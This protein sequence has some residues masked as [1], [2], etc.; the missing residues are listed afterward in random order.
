MPVVT[1]ALYRSWRTQREKDRP[2]KATTDNVA[3]MPKAFRK[4]I[5]IVFQKPSHGT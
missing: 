2:I 5:K 3:N 4:I 1:V